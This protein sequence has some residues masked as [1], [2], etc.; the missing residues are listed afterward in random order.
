[1]LLIK[2]D[3]PTHIKD[4]LEAGA[5]YN[6]LEAVELLSSESIPTIKEIIEAGKMI[7]DK[8]VDGNLAYTKEAAHSRNRILHAQGDATGR[9]IHL[10]LLEHC[11]HEIVTQ[12]VVCDLLIQDDVCY[13]VQ[14]FTSEHEQ[15]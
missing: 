14:Y 3:I 13:G 12:A 1:M 15:K 10:F 7:F 5:N 4:T 9:E 11:P 6:N 8:N 2:N